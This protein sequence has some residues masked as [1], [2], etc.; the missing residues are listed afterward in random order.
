M[1]ASLV[2]W[3][4]VSVL[5]ASP[6]N[7]WTQLKNNYPGTPVSCT[8]T[9]TWPCIEWAKTSSNLSIT[10]DVYLHS[11]LLQN[12][13]DIRTD[14][15]NSFSEYNNI[16]ARNPFLRETTSTSSDEIYAWAGVMSEGVYAG[17]SI[18]VQ[19]SQ[20]YHIT[21]ADIEFNSE[22]V[23]NRSLDFGL[24]YPEPGTTLYHADSRKVSNHEMGHAEGLGHT[25][26]DPAIM[27][28]GA[29]TY[30]HV[31]ANDRSGIIAIY[32]AYP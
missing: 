32:G 24:T 7:A 8:D 26:I 1:K 28:Q 30:Y 23:W 29:T 14:L 5:A 27:R 20:P 9:S 6:A 18:S 21:H 12:N 13:I 11:S 2:V 16:A 19:Q 3:A 4:V 31:Q 15:R 17:T 10:V 22:I 25:G